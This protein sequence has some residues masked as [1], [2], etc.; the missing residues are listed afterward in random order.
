M[1]TL[2]NDRIIMDTNLVSEHFIFI[3]KPVS[4]V[5][6]RIQM[7]FMG[8]TVFMLKVLFIC[9]FSEDTVRHYRV[10]LTGWCLVVT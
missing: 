5:K 2:K 9:H 1:I 8:K 3:F 4:K 6:Y 10:P 7:A